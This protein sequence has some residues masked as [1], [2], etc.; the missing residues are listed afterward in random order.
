MPLDEAAAAVAR[1][2]TM[3]LTDAEVREE[4]RRRPWRPQPAPKV[5]HTPEETA[6]LRV[7]VQA[8]NPA[9]L[10]AAIKNRAWRR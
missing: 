7:E 9:E 2:L 5:S 8:M 1:A 3:A 10:N 6:A 4:L